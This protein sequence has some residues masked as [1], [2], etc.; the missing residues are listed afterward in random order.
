MMIRDRAAS[1]PV[2]QSAIVDAATITAEVCY[3]IAIQ[4]PLKPKSRTDGRTAETEILQEVVGTLII[5]E[6]AIH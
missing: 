1:N 5:I 4:L 3:L 2:A 6:M